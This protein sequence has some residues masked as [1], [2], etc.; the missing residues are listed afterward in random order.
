MAYVWEVTEALSLLTDVAEGEKET[1][2]AICQ[3][4]LDEICALLRP[5]AELTD[6]R[7]IT[8]A[9]GKALY[10]LCIKRA[11]SQQENNMT[12]FKAGDLSV[13]YNSL[14]IQQQLVSAKEISD[15]AM[16]ELTP[17]LN[18]NGFYFGKVD[19]YDRD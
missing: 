3:R 1:V 8:A 4:C 6:P 5:E 16:R 10:N 17:L 13:S 14:D 2:E 18:D 7:I 12:S 19:I 11:W 15:N 9:A